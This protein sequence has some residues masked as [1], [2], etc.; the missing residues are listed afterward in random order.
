MARIR[1]IHP[2]LFTD[3]AFALLSSDAQM[4][5]LGL[6]TEADDQGVFE[7]KPMTLRMRLRP[8][9]DGAV[10]G[11]LGELAA[12]DIIKQYVLGS[13]K[14][15]AIRNFR[16]YQRPK[17]PNAIHPM[18][19]EIRIYVALTKAITE[20]VDD[21]PPSFPPNGEIAPQME[22]EGG[23]RKEEGEKK[24]R[25]DSRA[26]SVASPGN[27]MSNLPDYYAPSELVLEAMGA[28]PNNYGMWAGQRPRVGEWLKKWDLELDILPTVRSSV[29][30]R[31]ASGKSPI[32]RFEFF[33]DAIADAFASR[34]APL[35][36]GTPERRDGNNGIRASIES[37]I[38][39]LRGGFGDQRGAGDVRAL[40]NPDPAGLL[41]ES[42]AS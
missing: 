33:E 24:D 42:K 39:G 40:E 4:F 35:P 22:E 8:T 31:A 11:L 2:G 37:R 27:P 15:G 26:S 23:K 38:A 17:S 28:D 32:R 9:K 10:D 6:W 18:T 41:L 25:G 30:K 20:T 12:A 29:A 14:F 1:S 21:E 7:W 13:R 19:A 36:T 3:E 34:N 16:K 5:L